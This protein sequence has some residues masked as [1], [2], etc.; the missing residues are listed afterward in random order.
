MVYNAAIVLALQLYKINQHWSLDYQVLKKQLQDSGRLEQAHT[1]CRKCDLLEREIN[2]KGELLLDVQHTLEKLKI[3][4]QD[5]EAE[6]LEKERDLQQ[7]QS[8]CEALRLQV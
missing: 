7:L 5:V 4:N 3:R 1:A 2:S 6:V 8:E